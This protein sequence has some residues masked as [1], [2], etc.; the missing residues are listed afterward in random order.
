MDFVDSQKDMRRAYLSGST[1][2]LVSGLVWL[3]AATV[4][5]LHSDTA[6][7]LTLFLGGTLIF[8][9]SVQLSKLLGAKSTHSNQNVLKHLA[10][11]NLGV[12]FGG[13]FISFIAAQ[14]N[15]SLFYPFMLLTIGARYLTFQS[16]YGLKVYW[17]LGIMLM[18][19]GGVI[20]A[21]SQEFV[22]GAFAGGTIEIVF[23]LYLFWASQ[24][25]VSATI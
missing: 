21:T 6:S 17:A 15:P 13:L 12:L 23:A 10:I 22:I 5:L 4:S 20:V 1:G 2:V 7:M 16:V 11:E 24:K 19:A 18:F 3:I 8:P 9:I 14:Y 25:V